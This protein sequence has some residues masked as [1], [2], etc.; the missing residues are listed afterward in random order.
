MVP[1]TVDPSCDGYVQWERQ[2]VSS[3]GRFLVEVIIDNTWIFVVP[4]SVDG[5]RS[6]RKKTFEFLVNK[7]CNVFTSSKQGIGVGHREC[8]D[9]LALQVEQFVRHA[10]EEK[11]QSEKAYSDKV[12]HE[13]E[14]FH[15]RC[16]SSV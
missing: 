2:A 12:L 13:L 16:F 7:F 4:F 5:G 8:A 1:R 14:D 11:A 3:L 10:I 15:W 9:G 6:I